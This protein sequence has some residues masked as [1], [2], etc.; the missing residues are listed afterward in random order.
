MK[1]RFVSTRTVKKKIGSTRFVSRPRK[2]VSWAL[3]KI[4]FGSNFR[5]LVIKSAHEFAQK[6]F[7]LY[8]R[9]SKMP[10]KTV[11]YPF[12]RIFE[13]NF[14]F[15][16]PLVNPFFTFFRTTFYTGTLF[17]FP[18]PKS[19]SR[20]RI[21]FFSRA[22]PE[23]APNPLPAKN[24]YNFNL[25]KFCDHPWVK[26]FKKLPSFKQKFGFF[27]IKIK[28]AGAA[29]FERVQRGLSGCREVWAGAS[30]FE[31]VQ[32]GVSGCS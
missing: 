4:R 14:L 16:R 24:S 19:F 10:V 20:A 11:F 5:S 31:G 29:R 28:C 23:W 6:E 26:F 3:V 7:F 17:F 25:K 13:C 27:P 8:L 30:R 21:L 2:L 22:T 15:L 18:V 9:N 32:R 12:P 1:T